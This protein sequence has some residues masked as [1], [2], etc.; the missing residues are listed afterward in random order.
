MPTTE[1]FWNQMGAYNAAALPVH[2]IMMIAAA[3]PHV[4]KEVYVEDC[5]LFAAGV[6]GLVL[7]VKTRKTMGVS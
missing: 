1:T 2:I 6:L 4:D 3:I 7:Q 5:L